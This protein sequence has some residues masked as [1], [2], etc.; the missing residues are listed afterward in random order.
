LSLTRHLSLDAINKVAT[1]GQLEQQLDELLAVGSADPRSRTPTDRSAPSKSKKH[2]NK[3]D[4]LGLTSD[5]DDKA[6]AHRKANEAQRQER[7]Q[8]AL[9]LG[10]A[11]SSLHTQVV[12]GAKRANTE[13][14][15]ALLT[16]R[17][18]TELLLKELIS[19]SH[20]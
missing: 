3:S 16:R 2:N 7:A 20:R 8:R 5:E 14:A 1:A 17:E 19:T 4:G 10:N 11:V 18:D 6:R 13:L 12:D 9:A 15:K